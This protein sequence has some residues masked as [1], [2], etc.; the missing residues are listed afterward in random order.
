[1]TD[2]GTKGA[3]SRLSKLRSSPFAPIVYPNTA[4][5]HVSFPEWARA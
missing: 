3:L 2:F 1:M 5:F 4:G